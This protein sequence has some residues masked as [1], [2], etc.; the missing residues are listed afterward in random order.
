MPALLRALRTSLPAQPLTAAAVLQY[1]G[2]GGRSA[3]GVD[4]NAQT[5]MRH[6]AVLRAIELTAGTVASLPLKTYRDTT[7]PDG[8]SARQEISNQ[9]FLDPMH[10]E[11]DIT[12]Y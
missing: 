1:L 5:A 12:W 11:L 6:M 2:G 10:A 4:V 7:G 9:L 8:E 3:S